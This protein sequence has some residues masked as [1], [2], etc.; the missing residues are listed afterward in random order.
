MANLDKILFLGDVHS[1]HHDKKAWELVM[2]VAQDFKPN[3][4]IL[5]GDFLDCFTVS[6]YSKSPLRATQ[7][8]DEVVEAKSMLEQLDNLKAK[9]KIFVAG[10]HEDRLR[11]YLQDKAPEL[12]STISVPKILEL[13]KRKWQYIEY[14]E[15]YKLGKLYITHDVSTAGRY[16]AYRAL[17]TFQH[18]VATAHSHRLSYVVEGNATGEALCSASFGWLGDVDQIDYMSKMA[19]K[20]NWALGFGVGYLEKTSESVYINPIAIVNYTC[21][22]E[23]KHYGLL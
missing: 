15:H 23:G 9:R 12:F 14:K 21:V 16:S 18:P 20:K 13:D 6:S 8:E 10:N 2:N 22:V 3:T 5:L 7:L 11:R 4:I 17:E 1:P 19:A